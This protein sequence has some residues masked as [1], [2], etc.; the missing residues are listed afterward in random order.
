M[1]LD[2]SIVKTLAKG[3]AIIFISL[4]LG[5]CYS[6][7]AALMPRAPD[8]YPEEIRQMCERDGGLR[9]FETA[10]GVNSIYFSGVK[11]G[12]I[13]GQNFSVGWQGCDEDCAD[14]LLR[15]K[16][17]YFE[18]SVTPGNAHA[19]E[20]QL[21]TPGE[22][23]LF[24]FTLKKTGHP[25]CE[26]FEIVRPLMYS[27]SSN[28]A[29]YYK[30]PPEVCIATSRID[31]ITSRYEVA[32]KRLRIDH[33]GSDFTSK[34]IHTIHDRVNQRL[35]ASSIRY[36]YHLSPVIGPR[37]RNICPQDW[38]PISFRAVLRP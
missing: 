38:Q 22:S 18:A 6:L 14:A 11:K 20:R 36:Y 19:S 3:L 4:A 9:I 21:I 16:F 5:G 8:S 37:D 23:G 30:L 26:P 32:F 31:K 17:D 7:F 28:Y 29:Y 27:G 24:R 35:L 34:H 2:R 1:M 33:S 12:Q 25:D 10:S 15:D 13:D